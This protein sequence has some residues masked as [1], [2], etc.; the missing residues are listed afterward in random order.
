MPATVAIISVVVPSGVCA[1]L[2]ENKSSRSN[3]IEQCCVED[4]SLVEVFGVIRQ[5]RDGSLTQSLQF[6]G[7][8]ERPGSIF[9]LLADSGTLRFRKILRHS[10]VTDSNGCVSTNLHRGAA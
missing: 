5:T 3:S 9:Y 1:E 2:K 4:C 6:V 10:H 7:F 8:R